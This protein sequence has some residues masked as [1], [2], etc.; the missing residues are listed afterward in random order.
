M[1]LMVNAVATADSDIALCAEDYPTDFV[2]GRHPADY[3]VSNAP[4]SPAHI[5]HHARGRHNRLWFRVSWFRPQDQNYVAMSFLLDTGAPKHMNLSHEAMCTLEDSGLVCVDDDMD[6]Q[7]VKLAGR[8]CPVELTPAM[9]APANLIGLKLLKRL[10]LR[11]WEDHPHFSF[12]TDVRVFGA[13]S[14][15]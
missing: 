2:C 7:Y 6:I 3:I 4:I 11:L 5:Y 13:D 14:F 10:G 8:K 9:H 1:S 12:E 15:A